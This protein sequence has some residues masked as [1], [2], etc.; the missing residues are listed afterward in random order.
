MSGRMLT[1][2]LAHRGRAHLL[3]FEVPDFP[4]VVAN[5]AYF[6]HAARLLCLPVADAE[7]VHDGTGRPGLLVTRFDRE[8]ASDGTLRRLP[9]EDAAQLLGVY[10]ADKY[11]VSAEDVA[12]RAGAVCAARPVALR[13]VLAQLCSP[14]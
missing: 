12:T 1:V 13:A 7:V 10:S 2:P 11:S 9:V 4:H 6:L 8:V 5:E 14:G 3:K